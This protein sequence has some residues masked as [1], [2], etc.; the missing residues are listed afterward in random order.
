M[1]IYIKRVHFAHVIV[2]SSG[3]L[4][5]QLLAFSQV[6]LINF[7]LSITY[8]GILPQDELNHNA[9]VRPMDRILFLFF[10]QRQ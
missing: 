6:Q 3:Q 5:A 10:N 2:R 7:Q 1:N 9:Q 8:A 4:D